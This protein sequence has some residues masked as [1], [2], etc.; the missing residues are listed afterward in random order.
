MISGLERGVSN[1]DGVSIANTAARAAAMM[2]VRRR[3]PIR[4]T[5]TISP[6]SGVQSTAMP[7]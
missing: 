3:N 5:Q 2:K 6:K 1:L 4:V 7:N